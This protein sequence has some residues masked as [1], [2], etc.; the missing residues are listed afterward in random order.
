MYQIRV[1]NLLKWRV[2]VASAENKQTRDGKF[3]INGIL[4]VMDIVH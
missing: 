1:F 3:Y 4:D 2:T